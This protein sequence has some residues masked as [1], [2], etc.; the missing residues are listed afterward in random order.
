MEQ[1]DTE[2][3]LAFKPRLKHLI[4][5]IPT[6]NVKRLLRELATNETVPNYYYN[7]FID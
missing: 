3:G 6:P 7:F 1:N 5:Y 2:L 4:Q